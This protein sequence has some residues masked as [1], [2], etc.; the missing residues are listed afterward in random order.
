MPSFKTTI[1]AVATLLGSVVKGQYSIDP[2][3]VSLSTRISWCSSE[4]A[5]CKGIC[6]QIDTGNA[7][8]NICDPYQLTYNCICGNGASPNLTEYSLTLP[9]F[10]CTEWGNQCVT[11]CGQDNSCSDKCRSDHLCGAQNPTRVNTTTTTSASASAT[12]DPTTIYPDDTS[13]KGSAAPHSQPGSLLPMIGM[14]A[15]LILG[16]AVLL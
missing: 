8:T 12:A 5:S 13:N 10:I 11:K 15:S 6:Q 14:S 2:D 9:Y 3:T 4:L 16:F 1:L 7:N